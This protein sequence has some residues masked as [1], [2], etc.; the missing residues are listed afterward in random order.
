MPRLATLF[1]LLL[2]AFPG[3]ALAQ[4]AGDDQYQDP[5]GDT[6]VQD[7]SGTS[8]SSDDG[9]SDT[10]PNTGGGGGS[11]DSGSGGSGSGSS[12][13]GSSGSGD[14]ASGVPGDDGAAAPATPAPE[15]DE[16]PAGQL[17]NTGADPRALL[18]LGLAFVLTGVGLRLRTIDPDA[19]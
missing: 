2:L 14:G 18:L 6:P 13:S 8:G 16:Q 10:P 11:G 15:A 1:C 7:D 17:P 12:G 4:G 5:F 9:L 3:A 19:Y